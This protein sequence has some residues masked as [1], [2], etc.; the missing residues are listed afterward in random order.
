MTLTGPH[1]A[2]HVAEHTWQESLLTDRCEPDAIRGEG[3][4]NRAVVLNDRAFMTYASFHQEKGSISAGIASSD[5]NSVA[6][7][8]NLLGVP[9]TLG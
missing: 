4:S 6:G 3:H 9:Q 8:G 7:A 1:E 2:R 5:S